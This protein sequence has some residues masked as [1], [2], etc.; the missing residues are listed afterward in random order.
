[1]KTSQRAR[2]DQV[3]E[4][5]GLECEVHRTISKPKTQTSGRSADTPAPAGGPTRIVTANYEGG[6]QSFT[7]L[8][9]LNLH[10]TLFCGT[11]DGVIGGGIVPRD[12]PNEQV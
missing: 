10:H 12:K 6:S 3:G 11:S 2:F 7:I 5:A 1:M 9:L 4:R 8:G